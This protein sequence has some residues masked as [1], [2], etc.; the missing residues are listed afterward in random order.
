MTSLLAVN[1][2]IDGVFAI[3]DQRRLGLIW[4]PNRHNVM[5]SLLLVWTAARCRRSAETGGN[6]LFVATPAQDPQVMAS[7]AVEV[8]YI[9]QGNPAPKD[10]ILIPVTL[11]DKNN[12]ST[13]KGWT[14]K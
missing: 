4:L 13:Y 1:P 7:K 8:G 12:I 10:P 5:N 9:L 2:K 11:I 3:N 6:T 14:M